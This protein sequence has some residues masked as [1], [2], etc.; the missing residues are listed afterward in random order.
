LQSPNT[1]KRFDYLICRQIIDHVD[2][3]KRIAAGAL[4]DQGGEALGKFVRAKPRGQISR[5]CCI[6]QRIESQLIAQR[7]R[8]QFPRY[9]IQRMIGQGNFQRAVSAKQ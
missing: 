1:I 6:A 2:H 8:L 5:N 9:R 3:E 7:M 4:S